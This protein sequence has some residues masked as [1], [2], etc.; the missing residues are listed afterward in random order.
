[1]MRALDP[2]VGSMTPAAVRSRAISFERVSCAEAEG[3]VRVPVIA[4]AGLP[5]GVRNRARAGT[6]D[7]QRFAKPPI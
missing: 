7:L 1:M 6:C 5:Q 3:D 4:V 2:I